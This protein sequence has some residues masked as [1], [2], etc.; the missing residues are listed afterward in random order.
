V[1]S[2][3]HRLSTL[4][5]MDNIIVLSKGQIVEQGTFDELVRAKGL[6][7]SMA[8]RQGIFATA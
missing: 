1:I 4:T 2:V 7:A 8:A 5:A 3:A 6:F